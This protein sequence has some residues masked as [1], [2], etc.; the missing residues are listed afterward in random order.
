MYLI[1]SALPT[2]E[3]KIKE[4]KRMAG[5]LPVVNFNCLYVLTAHLIKVVNNC[6]RNRMTTRNI[7]IVFSP[8]LG[9][10]AGLFT[11]MIEEFDSIFND[12]SSDFVQK[13]GSLPGFSSTS[14]SRGSIQSNL[15]QSY[16]LP[17]SNCD[18]GADNFVNDDGIREAYE[19]MMELENSLR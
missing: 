16:L 14:L 3:Q 12:T 4:L 6:E 2:R 7:C 5:L 9:I 17:D 18:G 8:T 15:G 10:P 19:I 11:M 1:Y 13:R